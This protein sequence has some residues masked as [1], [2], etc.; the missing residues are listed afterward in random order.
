[1]GPPGAIPYGLADGLSIADPPNPA[2]NR[3]RKWF[4][5][6]LLDV[7]FSAI[8]AGREYPRVL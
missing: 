8:K 3:D 6:T 5:E 2:P 1:M 4:G 7:Q